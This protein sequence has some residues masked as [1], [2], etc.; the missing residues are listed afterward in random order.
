MLVYEDWTSVVGHI[1]TCTAFTI[2]CVIEPAVPIVGMLLFA[3]YC[4]SGEYQQ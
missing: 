4:Y 3:H 1:F 2:T